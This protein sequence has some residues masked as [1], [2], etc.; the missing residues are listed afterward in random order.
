[1]QSLYVSDETVLF[2]F[3]HDSAQDTLMREMVSQEGGSE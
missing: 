3:T 1:M 2:I